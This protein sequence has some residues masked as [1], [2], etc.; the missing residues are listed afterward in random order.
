MDK[1][2]FEATRISTQCPSKYEASKEA[3][4]AK[5][6]AAPPLPGLETAPAPRVSN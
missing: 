6:K 2:V 4:K 3:D 5:E 1:Q